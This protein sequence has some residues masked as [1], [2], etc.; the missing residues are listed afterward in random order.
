[1]I[2]F[3]NLVIGGAAGTVARYL[4]GGAVY[5]FTGTNFPYGTLV[6]N[7][8]G[9]FILGV[10]AALSDKKFMLSPD[11]RLLLMIGFCGAFTTFS[12]LIFETDSLVRNGQMIRAFGNVF[13]SIILG[14]LLFRLGTFIGEII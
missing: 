2:K 7:I 9:C 13:A 11:A 12:T 4:L 3:V 10:L 14:F 5:R 8:G 1:M 6:V